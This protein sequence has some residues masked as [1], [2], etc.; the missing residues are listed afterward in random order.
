[1]ELGALVCSPREPNCAACPA[2]DFCRAYQEGS[3]LRIPQPKQKVVIT[4]QTEASIAIRK[5]AQYLLRERTVGERWAGLWDFVRF[6]IEMDRG[7]SDLPAMIA[8][9]AQ[10][11][12]FLVDLEPQILEL[13]HSVTRYRIT[14][15]CY[16]AN[17]VQGKLTT[18][19]NWKWVPPAQF[20]RYPLSVTA[21][22][23]AKRLQQSAIDESP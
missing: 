20:D 2:S 19:E 11:T 22:Q 14:L 1:M 21:R 3:Q 17:L 6:E 15:K 4:H 13:T 12:G 9:V 7:G 8:I 16:V 5:G 18:G 23:F 10:K